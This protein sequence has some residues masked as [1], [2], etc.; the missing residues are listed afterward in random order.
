MTTNLDAHCA[1]CL[2]NRRNLCER[3]E[4]LKYNCIGRILQSLQVATLAYFSSRRSGDMSK[5]G[6]GGLC[7][8]VYVY[9]TL[10]SCTSAV[11]SFLLV[12]IRCI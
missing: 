2:Y 1:S 12:L 9:H 11:S 7:W 5:K 4:P 10:F 6:E 8:V 3:S